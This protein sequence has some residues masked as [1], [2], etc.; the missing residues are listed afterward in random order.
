MGFGKALRG[1][2]EGVRFS[3][4]D[5]VHT[6]IMAKVDRL[7][8]VRAKY[9]AWHLERAAQEDCERT[10]TSPWNAFVLAHIGDVSGK[11]ILEIGCGRGQLST[12][13]ARLG[14]R[15]LAADFSFQ[16]LR[17][18]EGR[19]QQDELCPLNA[20]AS[21]IPIRDGSVDLIVSC[22]TIEHVFSPWNCL[23]EFYRVQKKGGRLFLTFPSYL[24]MYAL[25]RMYLKLLGRPFNSGVAIQ[26]IENWLFSWQVTARLKA[27]G[28]RIVY[29]GGAGHYLLLPGR[30]PESLY[31]LD[32]SLLF[33]RIFKHFALHFFVIAE[34]G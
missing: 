22:E 14:A 15:V 30:A 5:W 11:V 17:I 12:H 16:A 34:T 32:D 25:Y 8:D 3:I 21:K 29:T 9:D 10:L 27:I 2:N 4:Q 18:L 28:F 7:R 19:N 24:N 33:N 6:A 26:P 13:L 1:G 31:G 20:D 23:N